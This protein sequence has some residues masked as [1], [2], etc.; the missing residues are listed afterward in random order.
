[1][2]RRGEISLN[3]KGDVDKYKLIVIPFEPV[4]CSKEH[5]LKKVAI[6]FDKKYIVGFKCDKCNKIYILYENYK[7]WSKTETFKNARID[8]RTVE[9]AEQYIRKYPNFTF[10]RAHF[11]KCIIKL[12]DLHFE[13]DKYGC[14]HK[15]KVILNLFLRNRRMGVSMYFDDKSYI[16]YMAEEEFEKIAEKYVCNIHQNSKER[17]NKILLEKIEKQNLHDKIENEKKQKQ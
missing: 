3:K 13:R 16:V 6:D 9:Q 17:A 2:I 11:D 10:D 4:T 12:S 8:K 15:T 5:K 7:T 14:I 1:M